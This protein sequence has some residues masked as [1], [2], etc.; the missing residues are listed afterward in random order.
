MFRRGRFGTGNEPNRTMLRNPSPIHLSIQL[1]LRL[2]KAVLRENLAE[3]WAAKEYFNPALDRDVYYVYKSPGGRTGAELP[4][5]RDGSKVGFAVVV[6]RR[7]CKQSQG[8]CAGRR[9]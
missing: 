6:D 7:Q 5:G 2:N 8:N 4:G 3:I 9:V 1:R